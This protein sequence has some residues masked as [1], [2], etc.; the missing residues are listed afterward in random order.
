MVFLEIQDK[1]IERYLE[2]IDP[3]QNKN[4]K[5]RKDPTKKYT[6]LDRRIIYENFKHVL[7]EKVCHKKLHGYSFYPFIENNFEVKKFYRGDG[8]FVVLP[9]KKQRRIFLSSHIDSLLI[10]GATSAKYL[11]VFV[12]SSSSTTK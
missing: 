5:Y 7:L 10:N 6:H 8:H 4:F 2:K 9:E 11:H 1:D 3:S 12:S